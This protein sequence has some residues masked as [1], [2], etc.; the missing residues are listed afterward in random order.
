MSNRLSTLRDAMREHKLDALL[1]VPGANMRYLTGI[2]FL[3][4]LRLMAALIPLEGQPTLVVPALEQARAQKELRIPADMKLWD[5]GHGPQVALQQAVNSLGLQGKRIGI[6]D[7]VM[8]VFEL[9]ALENTGAAANVV[10]IS[11]MLAEMRMVKDAEELRAMRRA[12][13]VIEETLLMTIRHMHVGM[14]EQ[15]VAHIWQES[16]RA[17]RCQP[18]F[19]LA[20]GAGPNGANP[21]HV[22]SERTLHP[23]DLVVMDGGVYVDGYASDITRTVAVGEPGAEARHIYELVQQ[24]N[25]AG[26]AA[27]RPGATGEE[28]DRAARQVIEDG[29]Y[30]S[31]FIHR[32]GHG[33]GMDV[34]EAPFIVTGSRDPLRPGTTFTIEP[35]IYIPGHFGVR[36]EDDMLITENGAESLTTFERN[37]FVISLVSSQ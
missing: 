2:G 17:H 10:D 28:I 24:A 33:L 23:G 15:Q 1:L 25:A 31:N 36:I 32:T 8:R 4:K 20:V 19:D 7:A 13:T 6:E 35:G 22:N 34:H 18:S 26:R 3:T 29:G 16:I 11:S 21:H 27:C 9:R 14:T 30:G 37:M 5:D 12:V